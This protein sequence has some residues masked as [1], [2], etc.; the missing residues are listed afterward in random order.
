MIPARFRGKIISALRKLTYSWEPRK[1]VLEAAKKAPATFECNDCGVWIYKGTSERNIEYIKEDNPD[2]EVIMGKVCVDHIDPVIDPD[3]GFEN[4]DKYINR[5]F[6]EKENLQVLCA[7]CHDEKTKK[8][9][10]RKKK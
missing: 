10:K 9:K 2:Q 8:E 7:K 1:E 5:M 6:C 3:K 4:W